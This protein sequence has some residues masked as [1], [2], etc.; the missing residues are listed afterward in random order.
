MAT[1]SVIPA[2]LLWIDA[3]E[4]A[5]LAAFAVS[6]SCKIVRRFISHSQRCCIFHRPARGRHLS[7]VGDLTNGGDAGGIARRHDPDRTT[8]T[9]FHDCADAYDSRRL[10]VVRSPS[11]PRTYPRVYAAAHRHGRHV[12]LCDDDAR[13]SFVSEFRHH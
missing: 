5:I 11:N 8:A 1:R 4:E 12:S 10:S 13:L 3:G 2:V 7:I 6:A 9:S